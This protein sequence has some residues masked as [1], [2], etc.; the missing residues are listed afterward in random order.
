MLSVTY[1]REEPAN[2][3]QVKEEQTVSSS[4]VLSS[5]SPERTMLFT[6]QKTFPCYV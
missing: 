6:S 1:E 3:H 5:Y 2:H 4:E